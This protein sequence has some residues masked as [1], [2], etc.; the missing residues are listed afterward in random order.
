MDQA[1]GHGPG[2]PRCKSATG[3]IPITSGPKEKK[4]LWCSIR[5]TNGLKEETLVLRD[6]Y[7]KRFSIRPDCDLITIDFF[8]ENLDN[9]SY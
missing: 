3:C 9:S 2:G 8:F 5:I 1:P 7:H 6:S 4:R